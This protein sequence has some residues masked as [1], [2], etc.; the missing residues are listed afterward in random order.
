MRKQIIVDKTIIAN[1]LIVFRIGI[2]NIHINPCK[3]E[4]IVTLRKRSQISDF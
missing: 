3:T 4:I 2:P 1:I